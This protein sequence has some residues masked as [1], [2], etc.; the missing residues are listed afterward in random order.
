MES[1]EAIK[2]LHAFLGDYIS[3][4]RLAGIESQLRKQQEKS[5]ST[6]HRN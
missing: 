2:V 4:N 3:E 1:L 5:K 6:T